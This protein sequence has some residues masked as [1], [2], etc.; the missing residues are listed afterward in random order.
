MAKNLIQKATEHINQIAFDGEYQNNKLESFNG[1][2][3]RHREK[4]VSGLKKDSTDGIATLP[5][6]HTPA[7]GAAGH[8]DPRR[9]CGHTG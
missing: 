4:V 9:G 6:L 2:T 1:D 5:P 7:L 8:H 3:I